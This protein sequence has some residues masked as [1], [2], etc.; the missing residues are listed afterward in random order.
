MVVRGLNNTKQ[1]VTIGHICSEQLLI[2]CGVP[3][4]GVLGPLLFLLYSNDFTKSSEILE[5]HLF[6]DDSN[7]FYQYFTNMY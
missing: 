7:L 4:G 3:Q 6:A 1:F 2:T 5:F